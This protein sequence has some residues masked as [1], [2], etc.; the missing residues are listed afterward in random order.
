MGL[1]RSGG[2]RANLAQYL[3]GFSAN[4]RDIRAVQVRRDPVEA[5]EKN[6]LFAVTEK[7]RLPHQRVSNIQMGLIFEELIR[8]ANEKSNETVYDHHTPR[9][10]IALMVQLLFALDDGALAKAGAIRSIYDP[11]AGTGGMLSVA[12]EYL[13]GLNPSIQLALFGQDY[14]DFSYAICKADM[15]IKGQDVG[16]IALGNTLTDDHF[17]GK[18]FDYGL[19]N[20]PF[21]VEWN[22]ARRSRTSK[23]SVHGRFGRRQRRG[24]LFLLHPVSAAG[25]R[26][27]AARVGIV[28]NGSPLFSGRGGESNIRAA[29]RRGP[30]RAIIA[31][32]RTCSTTP[33]SPPRLGAVEQEEPGAAW[34]G[35][36]GRRHEALPEAAHDRL[37]TQ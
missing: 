27:R 1:R 6:K 4:V 8:W 17:Q 20:P 3:A 28:L 15:V 11:T 16:N 26:M 32:P 12:D 13:R 22:G 29:A 23:R 25:A 34:Q 14:N 18:H 21:G 5:D 35:P 33:G 36:A 30:H 37:E 9:E 2:L 19:S 10:V 31:L 24:V 7:S